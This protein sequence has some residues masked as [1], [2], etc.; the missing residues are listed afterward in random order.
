MQSVINNTIIILP[1]LVSNK[2]IYNF[3]F[4]DIL[5]IKTD[6][7][8]ENFNHFRLI[9]KKQTNK[10][11]IWANAV[12]KYKYGKRYL[13][14]NLLIKFKKKFKF[15]YGYTIPGVSNKFF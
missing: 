8:P 2:I 11:I 6:L 13:A 4:N 10:T 5:K 14:I 12:T 1:G 15:H 7:F 9:Y 3:R